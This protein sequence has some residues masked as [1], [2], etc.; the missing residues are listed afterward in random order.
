[1]RRPR[2]RRISMPGT[3]V[4]PR[5]SCIRERRASGRP[6]SAGSMEPS[7]PA[8][9]PRGRVRWWSN[10]RSLIRVA[11]RLSGT[12]HA[13]RAPPTTASNARMP[14][15]VTERH[16]L[17][18]RQREGISWSRGCIT[19]CREPMTDERGRLSAAGI[20]FP[21]DGGTSRREQPRYH[22]DATA[23]QPHASRFSRPRTHLLVTIR[24]VTARV[25]ILAGTIA[26]SRSQ[27][28]RER[29]G[30]S[31]PHAASRHHH[32]LRRGRPRGGLS[33]APLRQ[34]LLRLQ[35]ACRR[36]LYP[37]ERERRPNDPTSPESELRS[38]LFVA[39]VLAVAP[40]L[41]RHAPDSPRR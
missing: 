41:L 3:T 6:G 36:W 17:V 18:T 16:S 23:S 29:P 39:V 26:I 21:A 13:R 4:G 5:S 34:R 7:G 12:R 20:V 35:G 25:R 33:R 38:D 40:D 14:A 15:S 31:G 1:M 8:A 2:R 27:S 22:R 19:R 37:L 28:A 30:D 24:A 32:A 11:S 9:G 10:R